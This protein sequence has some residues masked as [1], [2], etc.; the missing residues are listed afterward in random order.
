MPFPIGGRVLWNQ[1]AISGFGDIYFK[2]ECNA[3]VDD[4]TWPWSCDL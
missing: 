2:V 4:L 1:A 3:V